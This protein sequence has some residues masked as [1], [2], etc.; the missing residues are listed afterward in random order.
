MLRIFP[1]LSFIRYSVF[2]KE[3]R[4]SILTIVGR[5]LVRVASYFVGPKKSANKIRNNILINLYERFM[6]IFENLFGTNIK[7][8]FQV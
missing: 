5:P 2:V 7:Q 3:T 1:S 6:I 4:R 8:E